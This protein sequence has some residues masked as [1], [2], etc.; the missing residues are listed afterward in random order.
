[1]SQLRLYFARFPSFAVVLGVRCLGHKFP[2]LLNLLSL[3]GT[4]Q[5][6][7]VG[8]AL[9]NNAHLCAVLTGEGHY[10][11]HYCAKIEDVPLVEFIYLVF[12]ACQVRFP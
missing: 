4:Q 7:T 9:P 10:A 1:M 5:E 6:A 12:T 3:A 8:Y 2:H 11:R